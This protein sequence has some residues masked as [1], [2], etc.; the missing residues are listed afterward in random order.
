MKV[1]LDIPVGLVKALASEAGEWGSNFNSVQFFAPTLNCSLLDNWCILFQNFKAAEKL[2]AQVEIL[3]DRTKIAEGLKCTLH[4]DNIVQTA[5]VEKIVKSNQQQRT[6]ANSV[7]GASTENIFEAAVTGQLG[8]ADVVAESENRRKH[9][10]RVRLLFLVVTNI[11]TI[12]SL[13]LS[14]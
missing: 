8:P 13:L 4:V 12:R 2:Q 7:G 5:V 1:G 3:Q 11:P 10:D 14:T 9:R 6:K